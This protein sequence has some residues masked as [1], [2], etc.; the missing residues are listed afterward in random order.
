M[1][2]SIAIIGKGPSVLRCTKDFIDSFDEVAGCGR[3]V[4][5]GYEK[6][7]GDRL[8]Y[9][10]ANKTGTPYTKEEEIKLGIKEKICTAKDSS[11]RNNFRYNDLDPSTGILAF[12]FFLKKAEYTKI[13]LIGF[14]L[15]Q[16]G[17]KMYYFKNEEFDPAVNWLWG[18]GTYDKEG[19]LTEKSLHDIDDTYE[20]L[21]AMFDS[22]DDRQFYIFSSYPFIEKENL[23]VL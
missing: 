18:I 11:I 4:F 19:R 20:Y 17:E 21:N 2:K 6:Y 5:K 9:H 22:H 16:Q 23:K 12:D 7:V 15:F 1:P 8:H 13:A 10:F 14:D 3:P